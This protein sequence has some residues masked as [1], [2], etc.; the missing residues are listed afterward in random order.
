VKAPAID[1]SGAIRLPSETTIRHDSANTSVVLIQTCDGDSKY[2]ELFD[3]TGPANKKYAARHG[4]AYWSFEGVARGVNH[5]KAVT[6]MH[7]LS[8]ARSR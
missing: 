5:K 7:S 6:E 2:K 8:T 3:V 4:Y 1:E